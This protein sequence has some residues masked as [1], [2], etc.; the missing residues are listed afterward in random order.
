MDRLTHSLGERTVELSGA[1][2]IGPY[3]VQMGIPNQDAYDLITAPG[4]VSLAV[5]DG[6]GSLERSDEGSELAVEAGAGTVADLIIRAQRQN[7]IPN[8]PEILAEAIIEARGAVLSLDYWDQA[9]STLVLAAL[10]EESFAVATLGDSFGVVQD[11]S[12]ELRLVQ[13]PS[14]G[15][16]ANITKLL[17][18]DEFTISICWGPLSELSGIA[19]C[20]DAFEQSTLEQR[21][22][23]AGFWNRVFSMGRAGK[24]D[25][26]ELIRFMDGQGK[27]EDDATLVSLGVTDADIA[28]D[29]SVDAIEERDYSL[30]ELQELIAARDLETE[31][32]VEEEPE[33]PSGGIPRNF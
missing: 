10:T 9:G 7:E 14:V 4:L 1:T 31:E 15:E 33:R 29:F 26:S 18:S 25:A 12:G 24:L 3:H 16:F 30:A 27:I 17:T 8:L 13:P 6:A 5:A 19:L 21:V 32:A 22:P 28:P 2:A 11:R 20:S 23:T